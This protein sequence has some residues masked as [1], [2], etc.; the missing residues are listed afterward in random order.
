MYK[1]SKIIEKCIFFTFQLIF[2]NLPFG[3]LFVDYAN[4]AFI[5]GVFVSI[6]Q[7]RFSDIFNA[8][9]KNGK[10]CEKFNAYLFQNLLR[11]AGKIATSCFKL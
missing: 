4:G 11:H 1:L 6:N 9:D 7:D 2:R 5:P 10:H 3:L 8:I